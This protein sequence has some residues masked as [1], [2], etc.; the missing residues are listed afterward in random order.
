MIDLLGLALAGAVERSFGQRRLHVHHDFG[1]RRGLLGRIAQQL[2]HLLHVRQVL[3]ADLNRL[4]V[5]FEVVVAV[6]QPEAALL[7]G[8]DHLLRVLE[9]GL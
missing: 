4:L 1:F 9:V 8:R 7:R 3:L 2:K 6:R 5:V